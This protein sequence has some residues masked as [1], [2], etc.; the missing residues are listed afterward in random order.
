MQ[1][2]PIASSLLATLVAVP[3]FA[4]TACG[5]AEEPAGGSSGNPGGTGATGG[6]GG[7]SGGTSG[8][9]GPSGGGT[10]A[11]GGPM[12]GGGSSSGGS[13]TPGTSSGGSGATTN[14]SMTWSDGQQITSSI[15]IAAG[16]VVTIAPGATVTLA[17]NATLTVAGTLTASSASPTHAKLTGTGWTGIV[18]A[19]GGTLTLDGVDIA[20]AS[21]ALDVQGGA[22]KAEYDD[23]TINGAA[24]PFNVEKGAAL[25]TAHATVTT[26]MGGSQVSGAF[27]ATHLDYDSNGYAGITTADP[28]ATLSIEQSTLHGSG[29]FADF[30][31]SAGG[32]ASFHVAYTDISNVHCGFHFDAITGFDISYT[33]IHGNAFGFMLYGSSGNAT[34]SVSY[35]NVDNNTDYA[36][37]AEGNNGLITF[38]HCYVTGQ[39]TSGV[40]VTNP[41]TAAVGG[42]GPQP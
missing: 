3:L 4:V 7:S 8:S 37:A 35:S 32:A 15:T 23:G 11:P 17:P 10:T 38:D 1:T 9:T 19:S 33:N 28:A 42:T 27:T 34:R 24:L 21:A 30:L 20:G 22:A 29:P 16:D 14:G 36:Y 26:A 13:G 25:T 39:T 18:V 40:T 6:S 12:S 5:P 31:V 41:E 2:R